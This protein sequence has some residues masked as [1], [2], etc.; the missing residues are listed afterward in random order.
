MRLK[1]QKKRC[2]FCLNFNTKK[3]GSLRRQP[4]TLR[5]L[6]KRRTQRLY[7]N[8]C[9][10]PFTARY[11]NKYSHYSLDFKHEAIKRFIEDKSTYGTISKRLGS[12]TGA[13][14]NWV[15]Q[16]GGKCK[17][18]LVISQELKPNWVGILGIDGKPIKV[19]GKKKTALL[20][21]DVLTCDLVYYDVVS[22]EDKE[23]CKRF[24][25]IVREVMKYPTKAIVSDFG[26]GNVFIELINDIFPDVLHQA[27]VAHFDRYLDFKIP[28][29][30]KSPYYEYNRIL[31]NLVHNLLYADNFNDAQEIFIRLMTYKNFFKASYHKTILKSLKKNFH[32]LTA[33]FHEELLPRD[34]N[35]TEN[36]V[37]QLGAK[38]DTIKS[39]GS[40]DSPPNFLKL[41][42]AWYRFKPF[43]DSNYESRKNLSPLQLAGVDTSKL[44]WL[45]FC[46]K[47][48]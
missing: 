44:D 26:K 11:K 33:H 45:K 7:C 9:K 43:T 35:V 32:L 37:G 14:W 3:N 18:P 21:V 20:A 23:N 46:L 24:L 13:I 36:V 31:R 48:G 38:L 39:F 19:K 25:L 34:N 30:K 17:G 15:N 28:K 27:C 40:D 1:C 12:S 5:G 41:W 2:P 6:T 47:I 4:K 10:R 8:D 42:A 16:A 29:S 22:S